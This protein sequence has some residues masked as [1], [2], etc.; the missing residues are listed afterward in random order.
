[1]F[2]ERED[3]PRDQK[4]PFSKYLDHLVAEYQKNYQEKIF[5]RLKI[6]DPLSSKLS[7]FVQGQNFEHDSTEVNW[8]WRGNNDKNSPMLEQAMTNRGRIYNGYPNSAS[9]FGSFC[10]DGLATA[11]HACYTTTSFDEAVLTVINRYGDADTT[12]AIAGQLAGAFYGYKN[13]NFG[14]IKALNQW[15]NGE[16]RLRAILLYLIGNS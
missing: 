15:D 12:G 8:N 11:L 16:I 2:L 7:K 6:V 9:Y 5:D 3:A 14:T 10:V 1:M 4:L 13:I